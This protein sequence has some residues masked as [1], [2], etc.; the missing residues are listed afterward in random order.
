M[1]SGFLRG[2]S[3]EEYMNRFVNA[4]N[5]ELDLTKGLMVSVKV[6]IL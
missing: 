6:K 3:Y 2:I 1:L 5:G 4:V